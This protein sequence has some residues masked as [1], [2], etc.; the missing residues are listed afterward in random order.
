[1]ILRSSGA[2]H[3][4]ARIF[5]PASRTPTVSRLALIEWEIGGTRKS[6]RNFLLLVVQFVPTL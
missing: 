5:I 3:T 2:T 1:M 4:V 6:Q